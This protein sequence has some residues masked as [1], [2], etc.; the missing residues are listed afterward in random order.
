[1]VNVAFSTPSAT[2]IELR[3]VDV[4]GKVHFRTILTGDAVTLPYDLAPGA[5]FLVAASNGEAL[6]YKS[7]IIK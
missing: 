1:V 2:D 3:L 6:G 4:T 7:L 5:Y